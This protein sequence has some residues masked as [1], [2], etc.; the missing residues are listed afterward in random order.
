[1]AD[2]EVRFTE[3]PL[4]L[5]HD[6]PKYVRWYHRIGKEQATRLMKKAVSDHM[7]KYGP[8]SALDIVEKLDHVESWMLEF[9]DDPDKDGSN[10]L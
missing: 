6:P 10:D 7:K 5:L 8:R 2:T 3:H 1:V 9:V 4:C